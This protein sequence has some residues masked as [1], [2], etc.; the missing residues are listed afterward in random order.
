MKVKVIIQS[1]LSSKRLPAKAL[2]PVAGMNSVVL[3]ARRAANLGCDV[4]VATSN[5]P[6]DDLLALTLQQNGI[7]FIRGPLHDVQERFLVA[8]CDLDDNDLVIRLTADNL[9][10]D[11]ALIAEVIQ[12]FTENQLEFLTTTFPESFAPYGLSVEAFKVK[13]LRMMSTL[14]LSQLDREHVTAWMLRHIEKKQFYTPK[15]ATQSD[16]HHMRCTLDTY[17]DYLGLQKIFNV[18]SDPVNVSW[19]EL[20]EHLAKQNAAYQKGF[21]AKN[22]GGIRHSCITLGTAQLGLV[23]GK[24]NKVGLPGEKEANEII[25]QSVKLGITC[26]DTAHAYGLAEKR[27]GASLSGG[28]LSG[29]SVVTKLDTLSWLDEK[30]TMEVIH[31]GV[32]ASIFQSCQRLGLDTLP[33]LLLHRWQHYYQCQG[34]IWQRLLQLKEQGIIQHLGVS[35]YSPEEAIFALQDPNIQYLQIPF[36]ILDWRF[37]SHQFVEEVQKRPD[38]IIHAR[39]ALLQGILAGNENDWPQLSDVNASEIIAT[40]DHFVKLFN[41]KSRAD[42]CYA[43]V[44]SFPWITSIVV[45]IE[46][47]AQLHENLFLFH[48]S[49]LMPSEIQSLQQAF[50]KTQ[51]ALLNPAEWS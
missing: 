3:C 48:Q 30:S 34:K 26:F 8:T 37:T 51:V 29:I 28:K 27:I 38:I 49:E 41:R 32:D 15:N 36:N 2:L 24:T 12:H 35:V 42:L 23:Y 18:V 10:P 39:S 6:E 16:R 31:A 17:E 50:S 46:T 33:V 14:P 21:P 1:R 43:Y 44:R 19:V 40:L 45:G 25:Q 9:F 47:L 20:A 5:E 4:I 7:L 13:T 22:M 11:G